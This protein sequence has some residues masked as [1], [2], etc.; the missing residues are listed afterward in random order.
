MA[1]FS[2]SLIRVFKHQNQVR[3]VLSTHIFPTSS[4]FDFE[5]KRNSNSLWKA[6]G[7]AAGALTSFGIAY[8]NENDTPVPS[9]SSTK[10]VVF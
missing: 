6:I 2:R 8:C 1:S 9:T 3:H 10:V 7:L 4:S 5:E